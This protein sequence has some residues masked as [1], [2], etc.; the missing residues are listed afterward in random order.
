MVDQVETDRLA[1]ALHPVISGEREAALHHFRALE[2]LKQLDSRRAL[3]IEMCLL[4]DDA[5][6]AYNAWERTQPPRSGH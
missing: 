3:E 6:R 5:A 4:P 2:R 1:A